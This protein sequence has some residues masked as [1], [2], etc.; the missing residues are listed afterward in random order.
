MNIPLDYMPMKEWLDLESKRL[1][2]TTSGV[3]A[4]IKRGDYHIEILRINPRVVFVRVPGYRRP[5]KPPRR[6]PANFKCL[7]GRRATRKNNSNEW[8]CD[9]CAWCAGQEWHHENRSAWKLTRIPAYQ[10]PY[11]MAI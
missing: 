7:C 11:H 6:D 10:E 8:V 1:G 4:R 2:I 9:R 5:D 3:F